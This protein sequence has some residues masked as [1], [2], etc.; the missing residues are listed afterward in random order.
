M[1]HCSHSEMEAVQARNGARIDRSPARAVRPLKTGWGIHMG[2]RGISLNV[3]GIRRE[4]ACSP[5]RV[6]GNK[7]FIAG[8]TGGCADTGD[9]RPAY[10]MPAG[11][12]PSSAI[13]GGND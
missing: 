9:D 10:W 6:G 13:G 8:P 7:I 4:L 12:I 1:P 11:P 3:P 5:T 2:D